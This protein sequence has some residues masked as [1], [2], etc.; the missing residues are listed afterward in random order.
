MLGRHP[1]LVMLKRVL[2]SP[3][4]DVGDWIGQHNR[5]LVDQLA[6][7]SQPLESSALRVAVLAV[8]GED[9]G[10]GYHHVE[11]IL[12]QVAITPVVRDLENVD[13]K[14]PVANA[15]D[16]KRGFTVHVGEWISSRAACFTASIT[17]LRISGG[18]ICS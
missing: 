2:L 3:D 13:E 6:G 7:F 1:R 8:A 10:I 5:V 4:I 16:R 9:V 17:S 12:R 14:L 11:E 18:G 15:F